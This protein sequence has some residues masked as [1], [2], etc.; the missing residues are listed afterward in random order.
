MPVERSRSD[1]ILG[2]LQAP[3]VAAQPDL[4]VGTVTA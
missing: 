1:V 3:V 4:A 2:G